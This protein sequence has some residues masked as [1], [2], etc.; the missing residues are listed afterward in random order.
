M[1]VTNREQFLR[2]ISDCLDEALRFQSRLTEL[3]EEVHRV[4]GMSTE[5]RALRA[6]VTG[7]FFGLLAH[8]EELNRFAKEE[9]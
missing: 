5:D 7:L 6:R 2:E 4:A 9:L 3:T 1:A 8:L